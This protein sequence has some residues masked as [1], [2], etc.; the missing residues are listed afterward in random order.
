MMDFEQFRINLIN[1]INDCGLPI[2]GAYY[3]L[4]DVFHTLE[5]AYVEDM[6][7][8][9]NIVTE[10][11]SLTPMDAQTEKDLIINEEIKEEE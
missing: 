11:K 5:Q 8:G 1:L 10:T 2:G 9:V 7:K 4:K 3:V 6:N